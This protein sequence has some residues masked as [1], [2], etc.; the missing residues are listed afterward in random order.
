MASDDSD[1]E[2]KLNFDD[3]DELEDLE[4]NTWEDQD[5]QLAECFDPVTQFI[6]S[7]INPKEMKDRIYYF[8][9]FYDA[10]Y[11][12]DMTKDTFNS[13]NETLNTIQTR[14]LNNYF[15]PNRVP[16][17]VRID[18]PS[19]LH[20]YQGL[21]HGRLTHFYIFQ[22]TPNLPVDATHSHCAAV[23]GRQRLD[24]YTFTEFLE[25]VSQKTAR[26]LDVFVEME[27]FSKNM[28]YS[29]SSDMKM[30]LR[31]SFQALT[32]LF[33]QSYTKKE[34]NFFSLHA[35]YLQLPRPR[36][37]R[38]LDTPQKPA[39]QQ[40]KQRLERSMP[41]NLF[42]KFSECFTPQKR[43]SAVEKCGLMRTHFIDIRSVVNQQNV[44]DKLFHLNMLYELLKDHTYLHII[45][46]PPQVSSYKFLF[47]KLFI[48]NML[49]SFKILSLL[50]EVYDSDTPNQ[51]ILET[52]ISS[53]PRLQKQVVEKTKLQP[54][55]L[56]FITDT[57]DTEYP[58]RQVHSLISNLFNQ[59]QLDAQPQVDN[60]GFITPF[61]EF[62]TYIHTVLVR[63]VD[64][65]CLSRVFRPFKHKPGRPLQQPESANCFIIYASKHH[66][67]IYCDF[68]EKLEQENL[69][70]LSNTTYVT[71]GTD[72]CIELPE[73][74]YYF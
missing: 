53:N 20:V 25:M 63:L 2:Q 64:I 62:S 67:D 46:L 47:V 61:V 23:Y 21:H 57:L 29:S 37:Q 48:I 51:Y 6:Q 1:D 69:L 7:S 60:A 26:F 41:W 27:Q 17:V 71:S 4:I 13:K 5:L 9:K 16:Q 43:Q 39:D 72:R 8:K 32:N 74:H 49:K 66:T 3:L 52:L 33:L 59:L 19:K 14:L 22:D 10:F 65:Y 12:G 18:G 55:I 36:K 50:K 70:H 44:D 11:L 54:V 15:T 30:W 34:N 24:A 28:T 42:F 45:S 38:L 68:I 31:E 40:L 58:P 56:R 73:Q 35:A